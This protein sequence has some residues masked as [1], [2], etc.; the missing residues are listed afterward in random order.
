MTICFGGAIRL[1]QWVITVITDRVVGFGTTGL[2]L[3]GLG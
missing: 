2:G 3:G 1:C